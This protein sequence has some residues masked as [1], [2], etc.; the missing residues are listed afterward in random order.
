MIVRFVL[1]A[2]LCAASASQA[3][4]VSIARNQPDLEIQ[5]LSVRP[6]LVSIESDG[7]EMLISFPDPM[8]ETD[9]A[10]LLRNGAG[11]LDGV[12]FGY[13]T[14]LLRLSRP[15]DVAINRNGG[16][17]RVVV[18][19]ARTPPPAAPAEAEAAARSARRLR[20]VEAQA[21]ARSGEP[22]KARAVLDELITVAPADAEIPSSL[23]EIEQRAGRWRAARELYDRA[24]RLDPRNEEIPAARDTIDREQSSRLRFDPEYRSVKGGETVVQGRVSGHQRVG[25]AW[26]VGGALD[27]WHVSAR[28]VLRPDGS[29][30]G[31]DALR[32][33]GEVFAQYDD[34]SGDLYRGSLY[35]GSST[36][37]AGLESQVPDDDGFFLLRAEYGRPYWDF[38]QGLVS[39][40]TRDRLAVAR[41]HSFSQRLSGRLELGVN[42][43]GL[44]DDR[45]VGRA[46][47]ASGELRWT[48]DP[49]ETTWSLGYLL[50]GEYPFRKETRLRP[51]GTSYQPL[52]L[53]DREVHAFTVNFSSEL[54]GDRRFDRF[55]QLDAFGGYGYDRYG[56][57]GPLIGGSLTY[58]G[59]PV[60]FQLRSGYV[61][62]IGRGGD[63][64]ASVGGYL[65]WLW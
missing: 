54:T 25:E 32:E 61:N 31:I 51:D 41:S 8:A 19:P 9:S 34:D 48:I 11:W 47:T 30:A 56:T 6:Q 42:R 60:Q 4:T 35:F 52:P 12:E 21:M 46:A 7:R 27:A 55:L 33:R 64:A 50:D 37:G 23:A 13:D 22:E 44:E 40:G 5:V 20:L 24:A 10:A 36:V 3:G 62:N 45:D 39:D 26:R 14:L 65:M 57:G 59:G 15:A 49:G 28:Q 63:S 18:T 16:D 53:S 17:I 38:L 58:A 29:T 2:M 43:Y 1:L